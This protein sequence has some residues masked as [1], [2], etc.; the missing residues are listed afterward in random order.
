MEELIK[1]L[2][3]K[4]TEIYTDIEDTEWAEEYANGYTDA[5]LNAFDL[6][7]QIVKENNYLFKE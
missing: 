1:D 5:W 3:N 4:R 6:A 7:I 2:E